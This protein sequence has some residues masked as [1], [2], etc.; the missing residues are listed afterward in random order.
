M[1]LSGDPAPSFGDPAPSFGDPGPSFGDAPSDAMV[2]ISSVT[3]PEATS[4]A[5]FEQSFRQLFVSHPLPMWLF[6]IETLAFLEVNDA[7]VGMYG[8]S[9]AEFL[10]RRITDIRPPEDVPAVMA[11]VA[12]PEREADAPFRPIRRVRHT[13]KNGTVRDVEVSS[14]RLEYAGRPAA[15][16]FVTDITERLRAER[17]RDALLDRLGHEVAQRSAILEQMTDGV[18]VVGPN[19]DILLANQA[20]HV[21]F[22]VKDD[23][24]PDIRGEDPSYTVYDLNG[25]RLAP[26]SRPFGAALRGETVRGEYRIVLADGRVRWLWASAGPLRDQ[27]GQVQGAVWVGHDTTEERERQGREAQ[28]E[29]LRALGQMASGVAHDLNQYLGLMAG[30]GDLAM[31]ALQAPAPDLDGAREA[32]EVVVHAA[33]DGADTVK[34][35]LAFGRPSQEGPPQPL[36]VGVL[37]REIA[38]LT[39]PRWRDAAQQQGRPISMLVEVSGDTTINGWAPLLREALANLIFNAVD[40][41]HE[42]GTIRLV[43]RRELDKVIIEVADTGVGIP[44]EALEHVF[45]PFFTTKGDRGTG[46]GLAIVYSAAER[47]QATISASSVLGQ[48][49]TFTLTLPAASPAPPSQE[50]APTPLSATG[51]QILVVD[52]EP[53]IARMVRMML[54][55]HGHMVT[56]ANSGEEALTQIAEASPRFDLILSDLGLGAGINGWELLERV[57]AD[58]WSTPFVLSTGWGAQIDPDEAAARGASGVLSKPYRLADILGVVARSS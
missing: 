57:R 38:T 33:M 42:G 13:L 48:G 11:M 8:Y 58:G 1:S 51:R 16:V 12:E 49:T 20:A 54:A 6:D 44:P 24:W 4:N 5:A 47:H 27:H 21:L 14:R 46:L 30:Y 25:V 34:R 2:Q 53:A 22:G 45:E 52:D 55:P 7:A 10:A 31:R 39:A 19:G 17:E 36:D 15:L 18:V 37:L 3:D 35:L 41:L 26:E 56:T 43:A 40:A 32:L 28:G 29:K 50:A 23:V 9:R